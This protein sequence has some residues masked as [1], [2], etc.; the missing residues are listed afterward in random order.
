MTFA[1]AV[2]FAMVMMIHSPHLCDDDGD[3]VCDG[4][5]ADGDDGLDSDGSRV[6][7]E[8]LVSI[9]LASFVLSPGVTSSTSGLV[10]GARIRIGLI[11]SRVPANQDQRLS[12]PRMLLCMMLCKLWCLS[13]NAGEI[14]IRRVVCTAGR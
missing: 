3:E 12:A 11:S 1:T 5:G 13:A 7:G 14:Q 2:M 10:P 6:C 8:V 4:D 9:S